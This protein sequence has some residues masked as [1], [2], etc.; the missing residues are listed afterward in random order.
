[1]DALPSKAPDH[2][3]LK[4]TKDQGTSARVRRSTLVSR[5]GPGYEYRVHNSNIANLERA[6]KERVFYING[7]GETV[8]K[9]V[10]E[11]S[12]R[13]SEFKRLIS[14]EMPTTTPIT[15]QQFVDCYRGRKRVTYQ[16]AADS[17]LVKD[18]SQDDAMLKAF[19]KAEKINCTIKRDPVPRV[20]QPR[21]PRYNVEVGVFLRP[22][23]KRL[24]RAIDR[25]FDR[26]DNGLKTVMKGYNSRVQ[27]SIIR[28]KWCSFK[29]PRGVGLDA[30]RFDQH[31]SVPAL[32]WE[33]SV[34]LDCYRCWDRIL[35]AKLL[36]WQIDNNGRGYCLDGFLKYFIKGCRMSGDINTSMGNIIIMCGLVWTYAK[37]KG[38]QIELV[39]NGDDC[40][41]IMEA[42]DV[43][44]F[45]T[46][47]YEWF[48]EMG[49]RMKVEPTVNR[50]E[51][52]EFCQ[53]HP[54][55]TGGE[56]W[57]MVRNFAASAAKDAISVKPL[58]NAKVFR[59]W[60]RSVGEGGLKMTGGV[61]VVQNYYRSMVRASC[62]AR[63]LTDPSMEGG[64][65]QLSQGLNLAFEPPTDK[66][67]VSFYDAFGI[68]PDMQLA[69]EEMYDKH[70]PTYGEQRCWDVGED[71]VYTLESSLFDP[72]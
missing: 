46:G 35:L 51:Q 61:P 26:F 55:C 58:D 48:W 18:L 25:V 34:Y 23:E 17:L 13:M 29:N 37:F 27:A 30:Q 11:F 8:P 68:T 41:V 71:S 59:R 47:L 45:R 63:P 33:H 4:V 57:L 20:I 72:D 67:R 60:L 69:L 64:F 50:I 53:M 14:R 56:N 28:Q 9:P 6:L 5:M 36:R 22:L 38:I 19:V 54:V 52:I 44:R 39:N 40:M 2:P 1:M 12:Q 43:E 66:A 31:C 21:T 70:V 24:Y 16:Q 62:G 65:W 32:E 15:R 3:S 10:K 7:D 42:E 49:Y